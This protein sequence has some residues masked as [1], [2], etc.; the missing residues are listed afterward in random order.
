MVSK[1]ESAYLNDQNIQKF[2]IENFNIISKAKLNYI[3]DSLTHE[4]CFFVEE[5]FYDCGF[6]YLNKVSQKH[7][8]Q[9]WLVVQHCDNNPEFQ[10]SVLNRMEKGLSG[11]NVLKEDYAYLTDRVRINQGKKQ[12]YGTQLKLIDNC[13]YP[14]PIEDSINVNSRRLSMG[15]DSLVHYL[16]QA[17]SVLDSLNSNIS[18]KCY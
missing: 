13:Y 10:I 17:S 11:N 3:R 2:Y 15:L 18:Q 14:K 1:I 16:K 5:I 9:F 8:H 6:P 12:V 7:S 4:N